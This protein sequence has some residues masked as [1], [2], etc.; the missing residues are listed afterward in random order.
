MGVKV[1][2]ADG[3]EVNGKKVDAGQVVEVDEGT[4]RLLVLQNVASVVDVHQK[5]AVVA[6]DET[7]A[8]AGKKA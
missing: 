4:A 1:K 8:T 2:L 3:R 5:A 6:V 7:A